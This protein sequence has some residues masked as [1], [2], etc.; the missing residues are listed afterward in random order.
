V[1][2]GHLGPKAFRALAAAGIKVVLW[3]DGTV[4]EAIELV[5]RDKLKI[6]EAANVEGHWM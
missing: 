2:A 3:T 5:K 6:S 1:V 4:A